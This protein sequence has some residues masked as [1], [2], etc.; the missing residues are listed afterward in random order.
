MIVEVRYGDRV[1]RMTYE[2]FERRI[3]DGDVR[4]STLVRYPLVTGDE[5][6]GHT[7]GFAERSHQNQAR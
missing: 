4:A 1:Q 5:G 7:S 2:D 6:T 3:R